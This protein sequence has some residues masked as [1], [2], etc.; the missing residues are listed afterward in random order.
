MPSSAHFCVP[1]TFNLLSAIF[2]CK[3]PLQSCGRAVGGGLLLESET[4]ERKWRDVSG[5]GML[6]RWWSEFISTDLY[7]RMHI[8]PLGCNLCVYWGDLEQISYALTWSPS[9]F[10][11]ISLSHFLW[12]YKELTGCQLDDRKEWNLVPLHETGLPMEEGRHT[13]NTDSHVMR[14]ALC[15][16]HVKNVMG[17]WR[18]G[19]SCSLKGSKDALLYGDDF[20]ISHCSRMEVCLREVTAELWRFEEAWCIIDKKVIC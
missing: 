11:S 15:Q 2:T 20:Q 4:L 10:S 16:R 8:G 19:Q 12:L 1:G 18:K 6:Y 5:C 17:W 14:N 3:C 9:T 13:N 7:D